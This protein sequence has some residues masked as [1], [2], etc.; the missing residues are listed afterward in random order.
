MFLNF[1]DLSA[2]FPPR[3]WFLYN[4]NIGL[5]YDMPIDVVTKTL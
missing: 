5:K 1:V 2:I 4:G 3:L